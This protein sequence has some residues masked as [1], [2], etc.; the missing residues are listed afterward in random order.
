MM[1]GHLLVDSVMAR[2]RCVAVQCSA[3]KESP[4]VERGEVRGWLLRGA[5]L[6]AA[7]CSRTRLIC[8]IAVVHR[9]SFLYG[10]WYQLYHPTGSPA[11]PR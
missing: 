4:G 6:L 1:G 9:S 2:A 8:A 10:T 5:Y 7:Q 11:V 3:R